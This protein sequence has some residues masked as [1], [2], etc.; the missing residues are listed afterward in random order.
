MGL[1]KEALR[2]ALADAAPH[3]ARLAPRPPAEARGGARRAQ[4][5]ERRSEAGC[6]ARRPP[7]RAGKAVRDRR[8]ALRGDP[9]P[10]HQFASCEIRAACSGPR[11][12]RSMP[13]T[14][15]R[16][17]LHATAP[18]CQDQCAG[19]ACSLEL[20]VGSLQPAGM[21]QYREQV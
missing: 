5:D 10:A 8:A 9:R 20:H 19:T 18:E 6:V 16:Y 2:T 17:Q 14:L 21:L 12:P 1:P 15:G 3:G 11:V 4:Q 13:V 7:Q